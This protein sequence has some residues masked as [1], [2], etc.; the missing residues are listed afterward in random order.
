M[1]LFE[2]DWATWWQTS[3]EI[4]SATISITVDTSPPTPCSQGGTALSG[5]IDLP[6]SNQSTEGCA[7]ANGNN[8]ESY[9]GT[10]SNDDTPNST[11]Q[12]TLNIDP[13]TSSNLFYGTFT[14]TNPARGKFPWV[15]IRST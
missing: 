6:G 15:G 14:Y 4:V 8:V 2:G 11:G 5:E 9:A 3:T 1:S 10:W 12:F 13:G 7:A